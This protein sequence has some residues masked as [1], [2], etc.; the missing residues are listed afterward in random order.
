M[1]SKCPLAFQFRPTHVPFSLPFDISYCSLP[2]LL[3][4]C[5][6]D[7]SL[8]F[9]SSHGHLSWCFQRSYSSTSSLPRLFFLSLTQIRRLACLPFQ[10]PI[11]TAQVAFPAPKNYRCGSSHQLTVM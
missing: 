5:F 1:H 8:F 10:L 7:S 11:S 6:A 2:P 9:S 4:L 3:F